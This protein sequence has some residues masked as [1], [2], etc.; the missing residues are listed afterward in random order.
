MTIRRRR[1]SERGA[2]LVEFAFVLPFLLLLIAG[3]VDFA[4]LFH[5]YEV[6]TNAARE[7]AR[8]AVLPGYDVNGYAT[9]LTRVDQ[10][11]GVGG[12]GRTDRYT[13]TASLVPV[14]LGGGISGSGVRVTVTYT[15]NFL[16]VGRIIGLIN[17]TFDNSV[18]YTTASVMRTEVQRPV[19]VP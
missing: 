16:F 6:S 5:S 15:H 13:R 14:Q 7:G 4:L 3:I 12:A 8:L 19:P 17:G 1:G 18:T 10:Y 9:A 11:I 2:E